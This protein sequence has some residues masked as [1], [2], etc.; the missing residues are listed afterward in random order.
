ML[1]Y[2]TV[3]RLLCLTLMALSLSCQAFVT[4][5][6][7]PLGRALR[8]GAASVPADSENAR[9]GPLGVLRAPPTTTRR[10]RND[11]EGGEH[12]NQKNGEP[13][14]ATTVSLAVA[15]E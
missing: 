15:M 8:G 14:V 12:H 11:E 2:A 13:T 1:L 9:V 10:S 7:F 3:R 4:S 6:R 5:S